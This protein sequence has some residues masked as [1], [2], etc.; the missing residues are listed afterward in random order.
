MAEPRRLKERDRVDPPLGGAVLDP[1]AAAAAFALS[2][3]AP[4]PD[5]AP[6][7]RHFWFIRW[8]RRGLPP[9]PQS[10]LTLPAVNAVVEAAQDSVSGV[11]TRRFER[12]LE[13][14]GAVFGCLFRPAGF[15]PFWGRSMHL[16]T[17]RALPFA[18]VFGEPPTAIR[19]CAFSGAPDAAILAV[20]EQFL[21]ARRPALS[22][23][24]AEVN[25]WVE[26]AESNPGIAQAEAL[27]ARVGVG[28]RTLQR[29]LRSCVGIGPKQILRRY[30]LLEAAS[31]LGRGEPVDQIDLALTLGYADQ[32]HFV[33]DFRAVVGRPPARYATQQ[34]PLR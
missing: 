3:H 22:T 11:W 27:A 6:F 30:R 18:E 4:S 15:C 21:R 12:S 2:R 31:R 34:A 16:L 9:H 19:D 28:L 20:F 24:M 25:R 29:G 5:L 17:D 14:T 13:G 1:S 10:T 32:A 23:E 26:A 33:R 7:V 8:D